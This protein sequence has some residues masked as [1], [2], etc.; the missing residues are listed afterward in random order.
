MMNKGRQKT[1]DLME[2]SKDNMRDY[3]ELVIAKL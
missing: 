2:D 1:E 3:D